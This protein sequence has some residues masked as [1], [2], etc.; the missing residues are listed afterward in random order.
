MARAEVAVTLEESTL[1]RLDLPV[2][3]AIFPNRSQLARPG[4][5]RRDRRAT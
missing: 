1:R 2:E 5:M 4:A 3:Q